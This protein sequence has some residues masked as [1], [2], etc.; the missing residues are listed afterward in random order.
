MRQLSNT[1]S[2]RGVLTLLASLFFAAASL[3]QWAAAADT[4]WDLKRNK[5]GIQ[6]YTRPVEGSKFKAIQAKMVVDAS[7][8]ELTALILDTE[9]CPKWADLCKE[10]RVHQQ[11][12][13]TEFYVYTYN[14]VP[15][16]V[17]DR[18]A[19][20]H[21]RWAQDPQTFAVTMTA[22]ATEGILEKTKGAVRL[23]N[24]NTGWAFTPV[25]EGKVEV[26]M[27]AHVDPAGPTPAWLTNMLLVDSPFKTMKSMRKVIASGAY[28]SASV[29]FVEEP[30]EQAAR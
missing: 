16:P 27:S 7:L 5:Q 4:D 25:A 13:P 29:D 10:A 19:L 30:S 11:L 2:A 6:V 24:A 9:A 15:W 17:S 3:P 23:V 1:S 8:T 22:Q 20:A 18:D 14:N 12:S 26:T 21:V 28:R